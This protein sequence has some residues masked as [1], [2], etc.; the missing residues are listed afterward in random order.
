MGNQPH[1]M[2]QRNLWVS[3]IVLMVLGALW[4]FAQVFDLQEWGG[5]G[6]HDYCLAPAAGALFWNSA[7]HSPIG[8]VRNTSG[9]Q[10]SEAS[11]DFL[12]ATKYRTQGC[13]SSSIRLCVEA[14]ERVVESVS[15]T[16][17]FLPGLTATVPVVGVVPSSEETMRCR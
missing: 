11:D 16:I 4:L 15:T 17:C 10:R 14:R 8:S 1:N 13:M 3:G 12:P 6:G 7:R 5:V 9:S 2:P